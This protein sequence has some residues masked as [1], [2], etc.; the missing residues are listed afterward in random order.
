MDWKVI[1]HKGILRGGICILLSAAMILGLILPGTNMKPA[2][3]EN[4]L[5]N[6][7]IRE[8]S[9][10]KVG[11]KIN[12][13]QT[14]VVPNGGSAA[15]TE[16]KEDESEETY[17]EQTQ[18]NEKVPQETESEE[19]DIG[20]GEEGNEDGNQGEEGGEELDLDLAAVMTW[21]R[22]GKDAETIT[23]APSQSVAKHLNTA[24]LKNNQLKYRFDLTGSD[25]KFVEITSV[26]LAEGDSAYREVDEIGTVEIRL[27][28]GTG[29]RK[30]TFQVTALAEKKNDEGENV[31]QPILFFFVLK[32]EFTMDLEMDLYW[33]PKN[34]TERAVTCRPD[35]AAVFSVQNYDL[36]GR[37]FHYTT[38]LQGALA[39]DATRPNPVLNPVRWEK[40]VAL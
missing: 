35:Q 2:Q 24:Q 40:R 16:P 36:D 5:E 21:Y 37:E 38:E 33:K 29:D 3:P 4:P 10:R 25:A 11:D 8:I 30:Y 18:P 7:S 6:E 9:V 12:E 17:P 34:G 28:G 13:L 39:G 22:Y 27:P 32:C 15:P 23:C 31:Q 1:L 19:Q 26:D 14:I 20:Q